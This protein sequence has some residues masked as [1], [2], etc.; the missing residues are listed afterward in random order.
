MFYLNAVI[1]HRNTVGWCQHINTLVK[2]LLIGILMSMDYIVDVRQNELT[3][4]KLSLDTS[5]VPNGTLF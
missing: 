3:G 5:S 2:S 4:T 1:S